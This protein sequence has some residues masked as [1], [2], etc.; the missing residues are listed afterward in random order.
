[1]AQYNPPSQNLPIF[2]SGLFG[3]TN[4]N[5]G[6]VPSGDFLNFPNA[7]GDEN[8]LGI[9]VADSATFN[10]DSTFNDIVE[11]N[12]DA[13][14]STNIIMSGT[15]LTNYIEFPDG[16]QQFSAGGSG[17]GDALLAGGSS[18]T[19]QTFTGVNAFNNVGGIIIEDS[20]NTSTTTTLYQNGTNLSINSS[21]SGG[22]V[23]LGDSTINRVILST[24][25]NG[26]ALNKAITVSNKTNSNSVLIASDVSTV[27]QLDIS[28]Q[29]SIGNSTNTNTV[30]LASDGQTSNQLDIYGA[31][32]IDNPSQSNPIFLTNY[33]DSSISQ[34]GLQITN[35][36][37][38]LG[39]F[40]GTPSA[41][42][43]VAISCLD[44]TDGVFYVQ[45]NINLTGTYLTIGSATIS[46][47]GPGLQ[48]SSGLS[49][50]GN[51]ILKNTVSGTTTTST[52][53]QSDTNVETIVSNGDIQLFGGSTNRSIY[54][55]YTG[56][57]DLQIQQNYD[58][59]LQ[60]SSGLTLFPNKYAHPSSTNFV[61]MEADST[62]NN[63]LDI[64]GNLLTSGSIILGSGSAPQAYLK[65]GDGSM[66]TVAYTGGA[67]ILASY[68]SSTLDTL[69]VP[70]VWSFTGISNSLGNQVSWILYSNS[71]MATSGAS[72]VFSDTNSVIVP[73]GLSNYI[74]GYGT[75]I[76][77]PYKFNDGT[78]TTTQNTYYPSTIV[79]LGGFTLNA[80]G[81]T[82]G[83]T[84]FKVTLSSDTNTNFN[85]GSTLKLVF[86]AG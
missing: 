14:F 54:L 62:T 20:T 83:S 35:G 37:I 73:S 55:N 46:T 2:D 28:G 69:I 61:N 76:K 42:T 86:Y 1:M 32:K 68:T 16:S 48:L 24:N 78:T 15:Y 8:L 59:F 66:Q 22:G 29:V 13:T 75:A 51:C 82:N 84:S 6:S 45:G 17:T 36:G 63:Q 11:I 33:A 43:Y 39:S 58:E 52:L 23:Q 72:T 30:L 21:A 34:Y 49:I 18:T 19:P 4:S 67:P 31:V 7:Q 41:S 9:N 25:A 3:G 65:F 85:N 80:E 26:L 77:I 27:G 12:N 74:Y 60:V 38:K 57:T 5:P 71:A 81:N 47:G 40:T 53:S 64:A 50:G 79:A 10:A 56:Q 44:T 70:Y